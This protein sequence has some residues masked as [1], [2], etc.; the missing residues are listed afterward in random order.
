MRALSDRISLA[1]KHAGMSQSELARAISIKSPSV[2]AWLNG[3]TKSIDGENLIRAA[4]ALKV[5][6]TWLATGAGAGPVE[7][8]ENYGVGTSSVCERLDEALQNAGITQAELARHL[9]VTRSTVSYWISGRT[10]VPAERIDEVAQ[11]L[12]CDPVWLLSGKEANHATLNLPATVEAA[13]PAI[14]IQQI[15]AAL[16]ALPPTRQA[17]AARYIRYLAEQK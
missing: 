17:E 10:R 11:I 9:G 13:P 4:A 8:D 14:D 2:N 3:R 1:L 12:H 6:A 15:V 7:Q 16:L 5:D